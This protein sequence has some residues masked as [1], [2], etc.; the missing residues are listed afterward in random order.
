MIVPLNPQ[1]L[2][3]IVGKD[4]ENKKRLEDAF[5]V[6]ITVDSQR[7]VAVVRPGNGATPYNVLK[8]KK[9]LEAVA[10]GFSVD[11]AL[12]L[13]SDSY[14][15]DIV[16]LSEVSRNREDLRRI[17]S[18]I[19]GTEGRFRRTLEEMTGVRVVI[20]E[21]YVGLIGDYEQLRVAREALLRLIGGQ[22]H[23]TVIKF[24]ERESFALKRRSLELWEKW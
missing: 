11:D 5:N 17:K 7:S 20:G 13:A 21:K 9:A 22:S 2:G 12:L 16:D 8:A 4:G 3:V 10:L 14:D 1:R 18:R 24:L 15:M 23:S 19:I 6:V